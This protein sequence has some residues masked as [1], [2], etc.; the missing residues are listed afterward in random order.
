WSRRNSLLWATGMRNSKRSSAIPGWSGS[1][2]P[3]AGFSVSSDGIGAAPFR[4]LREA[5]TVAI[6]VENHPQC[7][8]LA[9]P[10]HGETRPGLDVSPELQWD[11]GLPTERG[12]K[13]NGE[14]IA[15]LRFAESINSGSLASG[16]RG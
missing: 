12:D 5:R 6:I 11:W 13:A 4:G 1:T 3:M 8:R 14:G 10:D 9:L 16:A 7:R 2:W 15:R